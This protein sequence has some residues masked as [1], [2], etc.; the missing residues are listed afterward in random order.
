MVTD[1]LKVALR[2]TEDCL[3]QNVKF[4]IIKIRSGCQCCKI[5]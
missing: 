5:F 2:T 3:Y 1:M 4:K